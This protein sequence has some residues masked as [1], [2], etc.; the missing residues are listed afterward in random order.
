MTNLK[1]LLKMNPV[2]KRLLLGGIVSG[3]IYWTDEFAKSIPGYPAE[4]NQ[5]ADPH[6]PDYG[7]IASSTGPPL[8]LMLAKRFKKNEKIADIALGSTLY[9]IPKLM[10]KTGVMAALEEGRKVIPAR[11]TY[12]AT[13]SKY[14]AVN[15]NTSAIMPT[16]NLSKYVLTA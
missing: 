8:A 15:S 11:F 9:G 4:L 2:E 13:L 10:A 5:K 1:N 3:L 6:L 16:R 14:V 12:P 7:Q